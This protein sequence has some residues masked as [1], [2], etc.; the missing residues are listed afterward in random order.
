[1]STFCGHP[2][3]FINNIILKRLRK[4]TETKHIFVFKADVTKH[5]LIQ[6]LFETS[7]A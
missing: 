7:I 1:M 5:P 2:Y 6:L 3:H 4:K